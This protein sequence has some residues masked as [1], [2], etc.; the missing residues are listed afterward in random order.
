MLLLLLV[1]PNESLE[2]ED[3]PLLL[4]EAPV[5]LFGKGLFGSKSKMVGSKPSLCIA[6]FTAPIGKP[7][8]NILKYFRY[9]GSSF[10]GGPCGSSGG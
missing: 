9:V 8:F 10:N 2:E 4:F 3:A 7:T 1:P 5:D 6:C